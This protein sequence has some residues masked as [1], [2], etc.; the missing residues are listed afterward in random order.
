MIGIGVGDFERF[1]RTMA[2][3]METEVLGPLVGA[4]A[5]RVH[6][7]VEM[8]CGN[9]FVN[10]KDI[11]HDL[12]VFVGRGAFIVNDDVIAFRPIGI[13][14]EWQRWIGGLVTCPHDIDTN[15][16]TFLDPL[17]K[18]HVLLGVVV[19]ATASDQKS[20]E[21]NYRLRP[22]SSP[23]LSTNKKK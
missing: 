11:L 3:G 14:V 9:G 23:L 17:V 13:I 6:G 20:L 12:Q 18:N 22:S 5:K 10:L 15:V 21:R 8:D 7:A 4:I 19:T 16:G 2:G 1:L